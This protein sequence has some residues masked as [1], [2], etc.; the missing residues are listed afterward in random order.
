MTDG[1]ATM[2]VYAVLSPEMSAANKPVSV[3][4]IVIY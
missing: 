3:T 4:E 2:G 1:T